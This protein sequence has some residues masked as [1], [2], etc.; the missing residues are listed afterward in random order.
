MSKNDWNIEKNKDI[1]GSEH[2]ELGYAYK[3]SQRQSKSKLSFYLYNFIIL[4]FKF[5]FQLV[6]A[7]MFC[8]LF[9]LFRFIVFTF[10]KNYLLI[11]NKFIFVIKRGEQDQNIFF[12]FNYQIVPTY[13]IFISFFLFS[14]KNLQYNFLFLLTYIYNM[15][16]FNIYYII[17]C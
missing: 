7:L 8:Y 17:I 12:L 2:T 6:N 1:L 15:L 14:M 9:T 10:Y 5:Y 16:L 13:F 11:Q 4:K 3:R